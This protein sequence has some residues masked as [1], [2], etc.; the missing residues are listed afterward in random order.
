MKWPRGG[1]GP[2][3]ILYVY[4]L[5]GERSRRYSQSSSSSSCGER[6]SC[7]AGEDGI[8]VDPPPPPRASAFAHVGEG[9]A[10]FGAVG[11]L[12][13]GR[14]LG[15]QQG[16]ARLPPARPGGP[17]R[18]GATSKS[19]SICEAQAEADR[20][21]RRQRLGVPVGAVADLRAMVGLVVPISRVI[22]ASFS[23]GWLCSSQRIAFG[24]SWRFETGV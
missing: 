5:E 19:R 12:G 13:C 6:L 17:W 16:R 15:R 7:S 24:R 4:L 20:I 8:D 3:V 1:S 9:L 23:S 22:C 21:D 10:R 18:R 14:L 11:G 2:S